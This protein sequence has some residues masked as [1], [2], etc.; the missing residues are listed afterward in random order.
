ML[1]K[2]KKFIKIKYASNISREDL[3]KSEMIYRYR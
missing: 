3:Q 2:D 1:V